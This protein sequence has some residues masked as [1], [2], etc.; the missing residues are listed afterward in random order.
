MNTVHEHCSRG[1]QKNKKIKKKSN[2]I[3]S[4]KNEKFKIIFFFVKNDLMWNY[5]LAFPMN[6]WT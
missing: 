2:E 1:F 3:K 4:F 5:C 6:A